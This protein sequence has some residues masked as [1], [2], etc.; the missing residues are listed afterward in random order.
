MKYLQ[1]KAGPRKKRPFKIQNYYQK[2]SHYKKRAKMQNDPKRFYC[3][4]CLRDHVHKANLYTQRRHLFRHI[5]ICHPEYY[6]S[7]PKDLRLVILPDI[8]D[9]S[10]SHIA[11]LS[12]RMHQD[13][14]RHDLKIRMQ[15]LRSQTRRLTTRPSNNQHNTNNKSYQTR[16]R[17]ALVV[18]PPEQQPMSLDLTDIR[19]WKSLPSDA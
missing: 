12:K 5:S 13:Q 11:E 2:R 18:D 16:S 7:L 8:Q 6:A 1:L 3:P 17:S 15:A 9:P 19:N 10:T 4:E 14:R